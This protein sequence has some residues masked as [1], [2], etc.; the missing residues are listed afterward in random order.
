MF[1]NHASTRKSLDAR[2]QGF[3][4]WGLHRDVLH[5]QCTRSMVN[6]SCLGSGAQFEYIQGLKP[7]ICIAETVEDHLI[8]H[9]TPS[10]DIDQNAGK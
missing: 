2:S 5:I 6:V 7:D 3:S 8:I 1:Q 9:S 4:I 10:S